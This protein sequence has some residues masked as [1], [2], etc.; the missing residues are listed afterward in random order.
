MSKARVF[1]IGALALIFT[2]LL[3]SCATRTA[4]Y[5]GTTP[6]ACG[7]Q[8]PR[9]LPVPTGF[10]AHEQKVI[11]T[12]ATIYRSWINRHL[13]E[14]QTVV[15]AH[16]VYWVGIPGHWNTPIDTPLGSGAR[17]LGPAGEG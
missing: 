14:R 17:L 9:R 1:F 5:N 3:A 12:P 2:S 8:A 4:C 11:Y 10:G 6:V 16:D 7:V 15:D 13:T